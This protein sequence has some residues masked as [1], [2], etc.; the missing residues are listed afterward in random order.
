[1]ENKIDLETA[2]LEFD[3]FAELMDLEVDPATMDAEDL[4]GFNDQKRKLV[5][6]IAR[7]ALVINAKGEPV[8]TCQRDD[9]EPLTLTF[10][11][12]RGASFMAMDRKKKGEDMGKTYAIMGDMCKVA[13]VTFANMPQRDLKICTAIMVLFLG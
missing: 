7:G 13:P 11:E 2:G 3:R 8:Y 1:M 9:G 5:K 12:P 10:R 6:A 4:K